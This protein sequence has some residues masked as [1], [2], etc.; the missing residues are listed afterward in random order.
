MTAILYHVRA[1]GAWRMLPSDF[2][3]WQTVYWYVKAWRADGTVDRV[4]DA[5]REQVRQRGSGRRTENPTP[6]AGVVDS[7]SLRGADT[8]GSDSR[9]SDAGKKAN[10][11]KRHIVTDTLGL[12]LVVVVTAASVQDRDGGRSVLKRLHQQLP[13]VR[14]LWAD[15]G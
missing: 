13:G 3:P 2:P 9:G 11:R 10:G 4:H 7:Q 12:L 8:V 1:G 14:H 5:L 15:G 6:S